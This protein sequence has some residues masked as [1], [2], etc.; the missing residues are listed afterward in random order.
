MKDINRIYVKIDFGWDR[1]KYGSKRGISVFIPASFGNWSSNL[2]CSSEI[3][4]AVFKRYDI[5][6]S[7]HSAFKKTYK[8]QNKWMMKII[9]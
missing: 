1:F 9:C 8:M 7:L 5:R 6:L 3:W 2:L 4:S